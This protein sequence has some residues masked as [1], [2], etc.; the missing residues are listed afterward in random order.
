MHAGSNIRMSESSLFA[1]AIKPQW[2][3]KKHLILAKHMPHAHL[4]SALHT[5]L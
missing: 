3:D 4:A 2:P 5:W 1:V